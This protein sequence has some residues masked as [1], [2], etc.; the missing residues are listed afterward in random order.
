MMAD[1]GP[2]QPYPLTRTAKAERW[3]EAI[4]DL[5]L[6]LDQLNDYEVAVL[7]FRS[8]I[9]EAFKS[10]PSNDSREIIRAELMELCSKRQAH[11]QR[12]IQMNLRALQAL[13]TNGVDG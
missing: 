1:T 6:K 2:P 13:E 5:R 7:Q 10:V 9:E 8:S 4:K 12:V 11:A 3:A